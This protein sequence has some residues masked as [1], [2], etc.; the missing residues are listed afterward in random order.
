MQIVCL[1]RFGNTVLVHLEDMSYANLT[2]LFNQYRGSLACFS[3]DVQVRRGALLLC[4]VQ[5]DSDGGKP[6]MQVPAPSTVAG[7][8]FL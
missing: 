5:R 6:F 7:R 8:P 4:L 3:D 2:R 1:R